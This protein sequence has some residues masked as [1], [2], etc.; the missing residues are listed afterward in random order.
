MPPRGASLQQP[1]CVRMPSRRAFRY[2]FADVTRGSEAAG[3]DIVSAGMRGPNAE[4]QRSTSDTAESK[5]DLPDLP[6]AL[7][8]TS[9]ATEIHPL[10]AKCQERITGSNFER[11][12]SLLD[13]VKAA[14]FARQMKRKAQLKIAR[15]R[16]GLD[17]DNSESSSSATL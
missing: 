6:D 12:Q 10:L 8:D 9:D 3:A 5:V 4:A 1:A 16:A 17:A 15:R 13:V 2:G 7:W 11:K 14:Q